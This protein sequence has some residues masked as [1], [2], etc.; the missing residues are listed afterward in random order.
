MY[1]IFRADILK[2]IPDNIKYLKLASQTGHCFK[3]LTRNL[4]NNPK[5]E[6]EYFSDGLGTNVILRSKTA[7]ALEKA[8]LAAIDA[9]I[10]AENKI[11]KN[12]TKMINKNR[13]E[14]PNPSPIKT[15]IL[16]R[17]NKIM[18]NYIYHY[19]YRITNI[20]LNKHYYGTRSCNILPKNDIGVKYF[21]S[22]KDK[23]FIKDQKMNQQNYKYKVIRVFN[24]RQNALLLEIKL[25]NKFNVGSNENFYNRSKQTATGFDTTGVTIQ[26]KSLSIETKQ[27]ISATL[28]GKIGCRKGT[29]HSQESKQKMSIAR[30]CI[31]Q[32]EETKKKLS[33]AGLG[34][35]NCLGYKHSTET[36]QKM[37]NSKKK[38]NNSFY[39]KQ[40][41][42]ETKQKISELKKGKPNKK[43]VSRIF[44][45]KEMDMGNFIKWNN[46]FD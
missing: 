31:T 8:Y 30:T 11:H 4:R 17:R 43:T 10:P 44:D 26:G 33:I 2:D 39:G 15:T 1:A 12:P 41:S 20:I 3:I 5:L 35:K 37:S 36:K 29:H 25:H 38:E 40:H 28:T 16:F 46:K 9:G 45:K 21:S 34:N 24:N 14:T 32:S 18:T 6:N 13:R 23:D 7:D 19:V 42:N 22:S 27:K